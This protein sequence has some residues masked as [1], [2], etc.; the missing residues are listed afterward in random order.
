MA[1][2]HPKFVIKKA[3]NGEYYFY[4]TAKNGEPIATSETYKSKAGCK[5]GIQ[6][7]QTNAPGAPID[8]TTV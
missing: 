3:T 7:V 2:L 6:S 4:L 1:T 8:D 5:N